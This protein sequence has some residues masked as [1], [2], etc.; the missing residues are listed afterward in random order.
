M[1]PMFQKNNMTLKTAFLA[2]VAIALSGGIATVFVGCGSQTGADANSVNYTAGTFTAVYNQTLKTACIECHVPSGSAYVN[3]GVLL[4][5]SS[6]SNAFTSLRLR[7]VTGASS[8]GTCSGVMIVSSGQPANSYLVGVL[9]PAYNYAN[10]GGH[11]G[12]TPY[13]AH[14]QDQN[15]SA[16]EQASIVSWIQQGASNN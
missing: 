10:F 16:A 9:N 11:S 14:L 1:T 3:N 13:S 7:S 12:C 4:D 8:T 6:Q 2:L 5:F 15:L